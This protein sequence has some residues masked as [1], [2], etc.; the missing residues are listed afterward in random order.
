MRKFTCNNVDKFIARVFNVSL[1][2]FYK[3]ENC[4]SLTYKQNI[5]EMNRKNDNFI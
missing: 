5:P 3:F 2:N 1:N 4:Q